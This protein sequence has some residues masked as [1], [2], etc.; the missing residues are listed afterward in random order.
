[1]APGD[2]CM[3]T[4]VHCQDSSQQETKCARV[5][6]VYVCVCVSDSQ[7]SPCLRN[8]ASDDPSLIIPSLSQS[9]WFHFS[10]SNWFCMS[11]STLSL[12]LNFTFVFSL[13]FLFSRRVCLIYAPL[14]WLF[15]FFSLSYALLSVL[16]ATPVIQ[17]N[18][19]TE[20]ALQHTHTPLKPTPPTPGLQL[21]IKRLPSKT[22]Q[23]Q[24]KSFNNTPLSQHQKAAG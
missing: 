14:T 11:L 21:T 17:L 15:Q 6:C 7:I 19:I 23:H 10:L 16:P 1:M 8:F 2:S 9:L 18:V 12:S 3:L 4:P 5:L 20:G 13:L 22:I 24:H